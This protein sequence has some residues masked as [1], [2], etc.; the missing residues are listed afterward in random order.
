MLNDRIEKIRLL[1]F[2]LDGTLVDSK[3]DIALSVNLALHSVGL[4]TFS[5]DR[6]I[7]EIGL[8]SEYLFRQ[9]LGQSTPI[10]QID[11]INQI[12]ELVGQFRRIYA[13]NLTLHTKLY[14]GVLDVLNHFSYL[15]KV[16]VT[17]KSQVFADRL[18]DFLELRLYFEAVFGLE[19][20][21]TRKPHSGPLLEVC[22]RW[23][24]LPSHAAMIGD[25]VFDIL[26]GKGAG[27]L[28]VSALYGFGSKS[29][30]EIKR[31]QPDFEIKNAAE[32]I[33]L[34]NNKWMNRSTRIQ[35]EN[36]IIIS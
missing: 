15:P 33:T 5:I 3:D 25:S 13:D 16:I 36:R 9:L 34:F 12:E 19:A 24:Q 1:I 20:F 26:A 21:S 6:I 8:G 28:T 4:P 11:Q 32:L 23:N 29:N 10:N 17:N 31:N 35:F 27:L 22:K 14:S 7:R 18:V 30:E 2:D